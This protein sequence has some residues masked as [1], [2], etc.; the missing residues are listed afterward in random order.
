ML[1]QWLRAEG[2]EALLTDEPTEGPIGKFIRKILNGE[3]RAPTSVE[4]NLF[5]ADRMWH[6][7]NIILPALKDGKIVISERYVCSSIVYQTARGASLSEVLTANEF[8]PEPDLSILIDVPPEVSIRRMKMNKKLDKFEKDLK[9]LKN[10][11]IRYLQLVKTGKL[12]LVNGNLR[13]DEV[14]S[15]IRKL[16]QPMLKCL[17]A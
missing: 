2:Y 8:A 12:R 9:L 1:A 6:L 4:V 16:V 11:R 17:S 5:A 14:Q 3:I 15:E 13:A 10:V 7:G